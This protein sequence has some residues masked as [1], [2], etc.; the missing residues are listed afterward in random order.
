MRVSLFSASRTTP[1]TVPVG[2]DQPH[3]NSIIKHINKRN[4]RIV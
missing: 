4:F 2:C 1:S 3:S